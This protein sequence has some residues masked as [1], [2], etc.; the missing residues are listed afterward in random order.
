MGFLKNFTINKIVNTGL[1]ILGAVV[2]IALFTNTNKLNNIADVLDT[3]QKDI[4]P[5]MLYFSELEKD[6]IQIQQWLTDISAT[7]AKPGF[8]DGLKEAE[9]YYKKAQNIVDILIKMHKEENDQ[10]MLNRLYPLKKSLS[11]Y[12]EV[13]KKMAHAYINK[14]TD[15]GNKMMEVLD[16]FAEKLSNKLKDLVKEHKK[17]MKTSESIIVSN[18]YSLKIATIAIFT[19]VFFLVGVIFLFIKQSLSP[20]KNMLEHIK[21][22]ENLNLS[23]KLDIDGKNEISK[24]ASGLNRLIDKLREFIHSAK[25]ISNEN[26]SI[27]HELS[28]T[29]LSIAQ[30]IEESVKDVESV[31]KESESILN[32]LKESVVSLE[33]SRNEITE[34]DTNL[35]NAKEKIDQLTSKVQSSANEESELSQKM[36]NLSQEANEV[37]TILDVISD[38]ADQTNLLALN[39][40]IEAARAGE[41]GRG[42]AVVADEVRKLAEKTQKSLSEINT[43][44]S[45]VVQ[46][47]V[48]ASEK[49]SENT[50][51][52]DELVKITEEVEGNINFTA[53]IV[54]KAAEVNKN[55]VKEFEKTDKSLTKIVT[56]IEDINKLSSK[57]SRSVEEIATAAE[58]LSKATDSLNTKIEEFKL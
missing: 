42:F 16:P 5:A 57:N 17:E 23:K 11:K 9:K 38:I 33:E 14:G 30:S 21:Q 27:S 41:H 32:E 10:N 8:D 2:A 28:K 12:Y 24:I 22:I 7:R 13:G 34:A 48:D 51:Q 46:S 20:I 19:F 44:I 43:N 4:L 49:M 15:E 37:K 47:I 39:A 26:S 56:K 35:Q 31:T 1:I 29:S 18:V 58:H 55:S 36:Q 53:S 25:S 40:A 6:V 52:I 54:N 3:Q 45:V 50:K